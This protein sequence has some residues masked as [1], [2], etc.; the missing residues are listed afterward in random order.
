MTF[1][2]LHFQACL[3]ALTSR[4]KLC[5]DAE[6]ICSLPLKGARVQGGRHAYVHEDYKQVPRVVGRALASSVKVIM[7]GVV[8]APKALCLPPQLAQ[9]VTQ[10]DVLA[11]ERAPLGAARCGAGAAVTARI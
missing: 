11:E 3:T 7:A 9:C 6:R 4:T 2:F 8:V 10:P 5:L 1:R